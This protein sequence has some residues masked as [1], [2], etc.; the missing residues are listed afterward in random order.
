[1]VEIRHNEK[2]KL[3]RHMAQVGE[4]YYFLRSCFGYNSDQINQLKNLSIPPT[5]W[6]R[7]ARITFLAAQRVP[8]TVIGAICGC[9]PNTVSYQISEFVRN[10]RH[11][12]T[13]GWSTRNRGELAKIRARH[14]YDPATEQQNLGDLQPKIRASGDRRE[15]RGPGKVRHNFRALQAA[16]EVKAKD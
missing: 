3:V 13:A 7:N 11:A 8:L 10:R 1:M 2:W 14:K 9:A 5:E 16:G 4:S 15:F 6:E 12:Y